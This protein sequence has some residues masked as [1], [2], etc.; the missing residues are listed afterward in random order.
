MQKLLTISEACE[1]LRVS[2]TSMYALI[3]SEQVRGY[4]VG[5]LG[6]VRRVDA[7]SLDAFLRARETRKV[8]SRPAPRLDL[9]K[10]DLASMEAFSRR[11][12]N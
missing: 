3:D 5:P 12:P 9:V 7:E 8:S 11:F 1:I 4:R 2:R 10:Y 6:K